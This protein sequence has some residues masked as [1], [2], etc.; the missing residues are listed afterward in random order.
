MMNNVKNSYMTP[1]I[2]IRNNYFLN[3][4]NE[5]KKVPIDIALIVFIT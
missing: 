2:H 4:V 3:F 5:I 1:P